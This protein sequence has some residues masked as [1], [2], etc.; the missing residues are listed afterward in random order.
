[1][2]RLSFRRGLLVGILVGAVAVVARMVSGRGVPAVPAPSPE[3]PPLAP[4]AVTPGDPV[5]PTPTPASR[6]AP[7]VEPTPPPPSEPTPPSEL[8]PPSSMSAAAP[9][10][11][12]SSAPLPTPSAPLTAHE[13]TRPA[14]APTFGTAPDAAAAAASTT[15]L[16]TPLRPRPDP[17][18]DLATETAA[19][20]RGD[21]DESTGEPSW[22][23]AEGDT[24]PTSHP[25]KAKLSSGI[26]HLPDDD[27]YDRTTPDRCYRD[28]AAA[29]EDG[30]RAAKR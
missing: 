17:T 13:G 19:Q 5:A 1:M 21:E 8:R 10:S 9:T 4:V 6:P 27:A 14:P 23:T 7:P 29:E 28:A 24:C 11:G 22:V 15:P 12:S 2:R 26:F 16:A 3:W 18:R 25:V 20:G 30:L